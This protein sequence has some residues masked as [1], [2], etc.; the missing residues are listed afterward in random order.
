MILHKHENNPETESFLKDNG[1]KFNQQCIDV[2]KV[3][4]SG[5]RY[6]AYEISRLLDIADGGRRLRDIYAFRS[7]CKREWRKSDDGKRAEVEYYL[8]IPKQPTKGDV[9]SFY[10]Q[11]L[12]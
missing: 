9:V 6:T 8:D 12:F 2:L 5:R 7:D 3:L 4:Y 11:Q 10:Q 1:K